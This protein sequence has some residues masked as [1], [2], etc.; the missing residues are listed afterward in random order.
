MSVS[1]VNDVSKCQKQGKSDK[2]CHGTHLWDRPFYQP[3][4]AWSYDGSRPPFPFH[5]IFPWDLLLP[6]FLFDLSTTQTNKTTLPVSKSVS[7]SVSKPVSKPVQIQRK[8]CAVILLSKRD[9]QLYCQKFGPD[10]VVKQDISLE[11]LPISF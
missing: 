1:H 3:R 11:I 2:Y 10:T 9:S 5:F 7:I 6:F 8:S 4:A